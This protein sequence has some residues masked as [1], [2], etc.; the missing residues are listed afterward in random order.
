[1]AGRQTALIRGAPLVQI[2]RIARGTLWAVAC[3]DILDQGTLIKMRTEEAGHDLLHKC[4]IPQ[5]FAVR[6]KSG[7]ERLVAVAAHNKGFEEFVPLYKAR[8]RWSDRVKSL[9]APLFPGYVFCRLQSQR[10]LPI[11]TIP[12]VMHFVGIGKIP[13]PIEDTEIAAIQQAARSGLLVEPCPF[14]DIGQR[15]RIEEGPLAGLDGILTDFR[16]QHRIVLSVSLLR[17]SISVEVER[18]WV[19]PVNRF[20]RAVAPAY[21]AVPI[22]R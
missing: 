14:L 20:E 17:R 6:V 11:L 8:R 13:T 21:A 18:E 4:E 1:M 7:T 12:G 2:N 3:P 9:E 19:E 5:W 15:V 16:K 10:R 22:L